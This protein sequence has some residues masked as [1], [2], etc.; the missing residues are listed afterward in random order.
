MKFH[1]LTILPLLFHTGC[2]GVWPADWQAWLDGHDADTD[3]SVPETECADDPGDCDGYG[4]DEDCDDSDPTIYPGA[5]EVPYDGVDQDC[6]G[7]DLVDVDGDGFV[8]AEVGGE[9]C[10]DTREDVNPEALEVPCNDVDEDCNTTMV[11]EGMTASFATSG[12]APSAVRLAWDPATR[13][14]LAFFGAQDDGSCSG[15]T[16]RYRAFDEGLNILVDLDITPEGGLDADGAMAAASSDDGSPRLVAGNACD[17]SLVLLEPSA[18][19][20]SSWQAT[21]LATRAGTVSAV[22]ACTST[23]GDEL[24]VAMVADGELSFGAPDGGGYTWS[25]LTS[26]SGDHQGLSLACSSSDLATLASATDTGLTS[27]SFDLGTSSFGTAQLL[28][29]GAGAP[30]GASGPDGTPW[31]LFFED[32]G[33]N[34]LGYAWQAEPGAAWAEAAIGGVQAGTGLADS[35]AAVTSDGHALLALIDQGGFH[36]RRVDLASGAISTWSDTSLERSYADVIVDEQDRSWYAYGSASGYKV[37]V[38]CPE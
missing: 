23:D 26:T 22:G 12:M 19:D 11:Q 34:V 4:V 10:D 25:G 2:L 31:A 24:W 1:R 6:D 37:G 7:E 18:P 16:L 29:R 3:D 30:R 33:A 20:E 5:P 8:A 35:G 13:R 32:A 9:D 15:E 21:N 38:L 28:H 17:N 27:W 36:L 14:V